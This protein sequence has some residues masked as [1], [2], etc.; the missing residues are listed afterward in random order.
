MTETE[1]AAANRQIQ[2]ATRELISDLAAAIGPEASHE[3]GPYAGLWRDMRQMAALPLHLRIEDPARLAAQLLVSGPDGAPAVLARQAMI[4]ILIDRQ[5]F[6][7][8]HSHAWYQRLIDLAAEI[9][10]RQAGSPML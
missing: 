10:D 7:G 4:T 3:F 5:A 8:Q 2:A 6:G 1:K 9:A